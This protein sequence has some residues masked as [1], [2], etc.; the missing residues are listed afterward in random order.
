[1]RILILI[2]FCH[3]SHNSLYFPFCRSYAIV[4][5]FQFLSV[6]HSSEHCWRI[7]CKT[8]LCADL[9]SKCKK[10]NICTVHSLLKKLSNISWNGIMLKLLITSFASTVLGRQLFIPSITNTQIS[11]KH[12]LKYL[13]FHIMCLFWGCDLCWRV[14][15][16][17]I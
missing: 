17:H 14:V 1:M 3:C 16:V 5:N 6:F 11:Y 13:I 7:S 10:M 12:P 4:S 9:W 15:L 8:S 2:C